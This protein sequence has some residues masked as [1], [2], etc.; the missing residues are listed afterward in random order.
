MKLKDMAPNDLTELLKDRTTKD[1]ILIKKG[2]DSI[3]DEREAQLKVAQQTAS[4]EL[5][6]INDAK[7]GK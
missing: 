4:Q 5:T 2:L 3:L 6:E 1:I 7:N